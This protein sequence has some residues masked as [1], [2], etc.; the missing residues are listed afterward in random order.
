M[1]S[2][3]HRKAWPPPTCVKTDETRSVWRDDSYRSKNHVV[4]LSSLVATNYEL[5]TAISSPTYAK[6][7]RVALASSFGWK[8]LS[9]LL[10]TGGRPF[11][12]WGKYLIADSCGR[13]FFF[14]LTAPRR[15]LDPVG[16]GEKLTQG[17][18]G[19][20]RCGVSYITTILTEL[21]RWGGWVSLYFAEIFAYC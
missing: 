15:D 16:W 17:R 13:N 10:P 1:A 4:W 21:V 12:M 8:D 9:N 14:F 2:I 5:F 19:S 3:C 20:K 18:E 7:Q 6:H 11:P